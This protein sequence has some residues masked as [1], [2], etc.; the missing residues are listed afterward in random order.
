MTR[1]IPKIFLDFPSFWVGVF[2]AAFIVF[3]FFR[4]RLKL[5]SLFSRSTKQI[6]SF[7]DNLSV[8]SKT[9]YNQILYKY[10]QGKHLISD[11]SPL[12][13][14]LVPPK[15]IAPSPSAIPGEETIDPSLLQ[16]A[17]GYDPAYPEFSSEYNA[18]TFTLLE[19]LSNA[20]NR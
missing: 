20:V 13:R 4:Y 8:T 6:K 5:A 14:V 19:A 1:F 18:P 2:L 11:I 10:V 15:C 9:E 7:R 3:L 17:L 16:Q 12:E